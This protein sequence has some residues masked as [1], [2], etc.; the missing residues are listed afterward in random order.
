M[1]VPPLRVADASDTCAS[2]LDIVR[3]S[4][5]ETILRVQH[6]CGRML[7]RRGTCRMKDRSPKVGLSTCEMSWSIILRTTRLRLNNM[8]VPT[9][10]ARQGRKVS[11]K[12]PEVDVHVEG[13]HHNWVG[14]HVCMSA[15]MKECIVYMTDIPPFVYMCTLLGIWA[16]SCL[17]QAKHLQR[18]YLTVFDRLAMPYFH[19]TVLC[20]NSGICVVLNWRIIQ[21][22]VG[23]F[24]KLVLFEVW[25]VFVLITT[26]WGLTWV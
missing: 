25:H 3:W 23:L 10:N 8:C 20:G 18:S 7:F 11:W 4:T 2:A 24:L 9:A 5:N 12:E 16:S 6:W 14:V 13:V 15:C 26:P 1:S 22:W 21:V 19:H 17:M